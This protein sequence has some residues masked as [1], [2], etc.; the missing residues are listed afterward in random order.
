[1]IS[2]C[3]RTACCTATIS[4]KPHASKTHEKMPQA[5]N[6]SCLCTRTFVADKPE[7][8]FSL[9]H[10]DNKTDEP[11]AYSAH[12]MRD[13]MG[14]VVCHNIPEVLV[15]YSI[16]NVRSQSSDS[17]ENITQSN[18]CRLREYLIDIVN[19]QPRGSIKSTFNAMVEELGVC[20]TLV[21][22]CVYAMCAHRRHTWETRIWTT[23]KYHTTGR[24]KKT[25]KW[26]IP[27][28]RR[29]VVSENQPPR[30]PK[31]S[32]RYAVAVARHPKF[33]PMLIKL[34]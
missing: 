30:T 5:A 18:G 34:W 11:A 13:V 9:K 15:L 27:S 22:K 29:H 7:R 28:P 12:I 20:D 10:D 2:A 1:M 21:R 25:H 16:Y 33:C 19:T 31:V 3:I 32:C 24:R 23:H 17:R 26:H 4:Y 14:L 6:I 8:H